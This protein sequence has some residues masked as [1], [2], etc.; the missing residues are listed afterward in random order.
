MKCRRFLLPLEIN[1]LRQDGRIATKAFK[2][3]S[4]KAVPRG[5][6]MAVLMRR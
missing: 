3:F 4:Q 2:R 5:A 1:V 6:D